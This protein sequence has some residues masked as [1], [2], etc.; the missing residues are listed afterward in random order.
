MTLPFCRKSKYDLFMK[1]TLKDPISGITEKY[2]IHPRKNGKDDK[3]SL[4]RQIRIEETSAINV[5]NTSNKFLIISFAFF[6]LF[7]KKLRSR[8]SRAKSFSIY[9]IERVSRIVYTFME[10]FICVFIYFF[11]MKKTKKQKQNKKT[12]NLMYRIEI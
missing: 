12:V 3:K 8:I 10:T 9:I 4:L 6:S 11:P 7:C 5:N 1:N 2:Y